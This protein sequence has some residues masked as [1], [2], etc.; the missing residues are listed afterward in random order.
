MIRRGFEPEKGKW[1]LMGG[2]VQE[3]ENLDITVARVLKELTGLKELYLE[4][5]YSFS[6]PYRDP[7][8][9]TI[10][11]AYYTL[12]DINQYEEQI[13]NRYHAQ[14]FPLENIP[15]LIFDH[16]EIIEKARNKLRH[17]A[18]S[19]P[20]LFE[21]L[22]D[23]FTLPQLQSLYERIYDAVLDKR[24]FTRKVLS[25]R[26]LVKQKDKDKE[27]SKRG[28]FYYKLDRRKYI[29]NIYSFPNLIPT[30]RTRK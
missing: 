1:S 12:I 19:H 16:Q 2:F 17:K 29:N 8:E 24:N 14:W 7:I 5:L 27:N 3:N 6:E 20:I 15:A 26:L 25:S 30:R 28:A 18:A 11:V 10:S 13:N 23:K 4:Q 9:R 21:L 22:P